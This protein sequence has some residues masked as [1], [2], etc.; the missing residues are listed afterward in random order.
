MTFRIEVDD[1]E[2]I[3]TLDELAARDATKA[4]QNALKKSGNFLAGRARAEA[5]SKPRRLKR[6]IRARNAK[7]DR[8]GVVV[9]ARHRLNAIV[10]HGT[11]DRYTRSGAYRGRIRPDPFITRTADRYGD[12]A[13]DMAERAI[14]AELEL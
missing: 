10:Q 13:L 12:E 4:L 9:S 7:R 14:S 11:K 1:R 2:V 6:S 8:P 5:P 3:R